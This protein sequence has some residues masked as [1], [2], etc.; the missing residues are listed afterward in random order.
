MEAYGRTFEGCGKQSDF[1][2]TTKERLGI[3]QSRA[4]A[5]KHILRHNEKE[6][7]PVTALR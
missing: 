7:M 3:S 1:N 4:V 6:G 2:V 5:L